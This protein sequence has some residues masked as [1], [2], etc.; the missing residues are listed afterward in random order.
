[1][2]VAGRARGAGRGAW[3]AGRGARGAGRGARGA[4]RGATPSAGPACRHN[5]DETYDEMGSGTLGQ[6]PF[7]PHPRVEVDRLGIAFGLGEDQDLPNGTRPA[8]APRHWVGQRLGRL[9]QDAGH[10][11]EGEASALRPE[12]GS[13]LAGALAAPR[14]L[15]PAPLPPALHLVDRHRRVEARAA[16]RAP[17]RRGPRPAPDAP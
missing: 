4:G 12:A 10:R 15:L 14:L 13:T 9:A 6:G 3:G 7:P 2:S 11:D 8:G 1:M 5:R 17:R 16:L